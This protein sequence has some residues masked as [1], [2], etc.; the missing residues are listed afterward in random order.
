[1]R[2]FSEFCA[3]RRER[4]PSAGGEGEEHAETSVTVSRD[5]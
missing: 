4:L 5:E 1:M 2:H 3:G